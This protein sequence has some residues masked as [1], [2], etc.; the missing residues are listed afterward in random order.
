MEVEDVK[1]AKEKLGDEIA[2]LI[3]EFITSTGADVEAVTIEPLK[4]ISPFADEIAISPRHGRKVHVE[5][6]VRL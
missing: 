4:T 1:H 5:V 6:K 3:S 2:Q